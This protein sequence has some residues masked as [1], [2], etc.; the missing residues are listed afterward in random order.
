MLDPVVN[1]DGLYY[2]T[3][4][5][6]YTQDEIDLVKGIP[7]VVD[8]FGYSDPGLL[9]TELKTQ[10]DPSGTYEFDPYRIHVTY[11][12]IVGE[13][14]DFIEIFYTMGTY[15]SGKARS[16]MYPIRKLNVR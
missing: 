6:T 8:S 14:N 7:G 4:S 9:Q 15:P 16:D 12:G 13:A 10:L 2:S 3:A 1:P 5:E 11:G